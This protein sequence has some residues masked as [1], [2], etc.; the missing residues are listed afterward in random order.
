[1]KSL[2][3]YRGVNPRAVQQVHYWTRKLLQ[4]HSIGSME[5]EDIEQEL[6]LHYLISTRFYDPTRASLA[7]FLDRI[8][9]HKCVDIIKH[10]NSQKSGRK[11]YIMSIDEWLIENNREGNILLPHTYTSSESIEFYVEFNSAL[12]RLPTKLAKLLSHLRT[13]TISEIA[14]MMNVSRTGI[15]RA[16]NNM[17]AILCSSHTHALSQLKTMGVKQ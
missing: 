10:A 17:R 5:M 16:I 6:M 15:Y 11:T 1:M 2:N 7:T 4:H 3:L 13:H 12:R 14:S 9:R 8:F